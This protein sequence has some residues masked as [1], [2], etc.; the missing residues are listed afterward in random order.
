MISA[1]RSFLLSVR[2]LGLKSVECIRLLALH[3]PAFPVDTN[4]GRICVRLGW[5]PLEPL[6]TGLYLHTLKKY[7]LHCQMITFGK[8][9]CTKTTPNCEACP[10]RG[11]CEHFAS[12]AGRYVVFFIMLTKY[13][14]SCSP[15]QTFPLRNCSNFIL[16]ISLLSPRSA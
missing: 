13:W 7:H 15:R 10:L 1:C 3:Q 12:A 8:V 9:F 5:V 14:I 4:V 6:P 2:G 16:T 11:D